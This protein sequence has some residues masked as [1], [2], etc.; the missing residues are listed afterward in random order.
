MEV[1]QDFGQKI[2]LAVRIRDILHDYPEGTSVLKELIQNADDAGATTI[3]F[4]L[5]ERHHKTER[6]AAQSLASFQ[7]P[8]LLAFNDAVFSEADFQS[9]SS[10]GQSVKREQKGKT[11]RFGVGFNASYHLS[12]VVSFISGSQLVIFD[13]HCTYLPNITPQNPG[14]RINFVA[15]SAV[16]THP[17]QFAP[18]QAFGCNARSY[19]DGTLFRFPL[20]TAKQAA[21]SRISKQVYSVEGVRSVLGDLRKEAVSALLFL[22]SL[23]RLEIY[24]WTETA[25][26]PTVLFTCRLSNASPDVLADRCFFSA[27]AAKATSENGG[28]SAT[29]STYMAIFE[30]HAST[31]AA[32]DRQTFLISQSSGGSASAALAAE[33][34]RAFNVSVVPYAAVAGLLAEPD[35]DANQPLDGQAFCFLPITSTGLPV[36]VNGFFEL[37]SNRRDIWHGKGMAGDVAAPSYANLLAKAAQRLGPSPAFYKL[38]PVQPVR[39]P[40]SVLVTAL[41]REL[42]SRQVVHTAAGGGRWLAPDHAVYIDGA[43][44]R[45]TALVDALIVVGVPVASG[46]PEVVRMLVQHIVQQPQLLCPATLRDHIRSAKQAVIAACTTDI[47]R[48]AVLLAYCL[49]DIDDRD[50]D[51]CLE[52]VGLP[53]LPLLDGT[54]KTMEKM[55]SGQHVYM[56]SSLERH[57]LGAQA[58][59]LVDTEALSSETAHRLRAVACTGCLNLQLVDSRALVDVFLPNLLPQAWQG[60]AVVTW[61][62]G[63]DGAPSVEWIAMLWQE[64]QAFDDLSIFSAWPLLPNASGELTAL[65]TLDRSVVTWEPDEAE[66]SVIPALRKLGLKHLSSSAGVSHHKLHRHVHLGNGRGILAAMEV[67]SAR[68]GPSAG[69]LWE[70][71]FQTA[72]ITLDERRALRRF[73]LQERWLRGH[74]EHFKLL[75]QLPIF[76][77]ANSASHTTE[78][79][80]AP[81]FVTLLGPSFIAPE[82]MPC[83]ALPGCFVEVMHDAERGALQLLGVQPLSRSEVLRRHVLGRLREVAAPARQAVMLYTLSHL[84]LMVAEDQAILDHLRVTPFVDTECGKLQSPGALYD[85]RI[86][87]LVALLDSHTAFPSAPFASEESLAALQRVGL[88]STVSTATLL[89][90][91]RSIA[92]LASHSQAAARARGEVLLEYLEVEAG[93]LLSHAHVPHSGVE[94]LINRVSA[95]RNASGASSSPETARF[96]AELGGLAWCPVL[97]KAPFEGLPWPTQHEL[98][99][100]PRAIRPL[101]DLW[102]CCGTMRILAA[103]CR[104]AVLAE[105][106]GWSAPINGSV[107]GTQ[108]ASLGAMHPAG[109]VTDVVLQQR[110]ARAVPQIYTCL[111]SLSR[112]DMEVVSAILSDAPCIWTGN[113]FVPAARVAFRGPLNLSPWLYC[114][115]GDLQPFKGLLIDLGVRESFTAD[116]YVGVLTDMAAGSGKALSAA[117][118]EQAISVLQALSDMHVGAEKLYILDSRGCLAPASDLVYNDAPW[119]PDQQSRFVHP[120]LSNEV[121]EKL[122]VKSLRRMMLADSAATMSLGLHSVE[123]FGQSEAL[124]TRLKHII[125]DYADGPGIL[126]ELLQNA[127]DAGAS[128]VAFMLDN[129]QYGTNSVLGQDTKVDRP[130]TTGRFGLGFN[131]VYHWTD[132]PGFVSGDYLVM[133]DPHAKWLPGTSPAQ[134]G[135]KIAFQ[136]ADLLTQFPDAFEPFLHFKCNLRES[137]PGTLFRFPLRTEELA[138]Q[139]EIKGQAYS[140][141][142]VRLLFDGMRTHI[143]RTLLFLKNVR[144]AAV[145]VRE[146]GDEAPRLLFRAS[147]ETMDGRSSQAAICRYIGE[148]GRAERE[149]LYRRLAQADAAELPAVQTTATVTIEDLQGEE[150]KLLVQSWLISNAL[151]GR[152]ARS[153]AVQMQKAGRGLVPWAGVAVPLHPSQDASPEAFSGPSAETKADHSLMGSPAA[154]PAQALMGQAFCF[155]PLPCSTGLPVHVNGYFE[156]SSNRRSIWFSDLPS[157]L[158]GQ[159]KVRSDWNLALLE[160]LAAPLYARLLEECAKRCGPTDAYFSLWPPQNLAPP[161]SNLAAQL[162]KEVAFLKVAWTDSEGGR[163]IAP[164]DALLPHEAC[165]ADSQLLSAFCREGMP[166]VTGT[167]MS[168]LSSWLTQTPG[169]RTITPS[170]AREYLR[171]K[172]ARFG[173]KQRPPQ[174]LADEAAAMLAYCLADLDLSNPEAVAQLAGLHIVQTLQGG[175]VALQPCQAG[176]QPFLLATGEQQQL[177]PSSQASLVLHCQAESELGGKLLAVASSGPLN[178]KPLTAESLAETVLPELLPTQWRSQETLVWDPEAAA[179]GHVNAEVLR[180]LW[181]LLATLPDLSALQAW[182]LV[183]V[184]KNRLC[185]LSIP[186]KVVEE[187]AWAEGVTAALS[188]LG[189]HVLDSSVLPLADMGS[190]RSLV[191]AATGS[192]VL[193]AISNAAGGDLGRVG[194]NLITGGATSAERQQLRIFLLQE[195]W[196]SGSGCVTMEQHMLLKALPVYEAAAA[197]GAETPGGAFLDLLEDRFL[198]PGGTDEALLAPSFLKPAPAG[199]A[200]VLV[201]RLGVKMLTQQA[202]ITDHV[203]PRLQEIAP[204]ARDAAMLHLLESIHNVM[205]QNPA[206]AKQLS[207]TAFV[208]TTS[209][210]AAPASLYDPR[211]EDLVALLDKNCHFPSGVFAKDDKVLDALKA[212]GLR[213]EVTLETLL[214]AARS[215]EGLTD[216]TEKDVD[217]ASLLL[218]KLNEVATQEQVEDQVSNDLTGTNGDFWDKMKMLCWCPVVTLPPHPDMPFATASGPLA[219][220]RIARQVQDAWICS[221]CL[222]LVNGNPGPALA[223]KLGWTAPL[224]APTLGAQLLELGK[225]HSQVED[226]LLLDVLEESAMQIYAG[227]QAR[228]DNQAEL[229]AVLVMLEDSACIWTG[230]GF[231]AADCALMSLDHDCAPYLHCVPDVAAPYKRL[232]EFLGVADALTVGHATRALQ[233]LAKE[234]GP[235]ALSERQLSLAVQLAKSLAQLKA[236]GASIHDQVWL[237][238]NE[239]VMAVSR[240]IFFD[241]APWLA[242]SGQRL[243]HPDIPNDVAE[244]L[245]AQSLRYHHQVNTRM[246]A[247]LPCAPASMLAPLLAAAAEDMTHALFDIAE[248]ADA[249]GCE[250]MEVTLDCRQHGTES[251]LL[252]GLA[253]FQGPALC[254]MLSGVVL[255]REELCQLQCPGTPYK[256]RGKTCRCGTGLLSCYYL[257]DLLMA[258][259]GDSLYIWDPHGHHLSA[260]GKKDSAV[261]AAKQYQHVGGQSDLVSRFHDQFAIWDFG[262]PAVHVSSRVASTLIR[263]PLRS[264]SQAQRSSVCTDPWNEERAAQLMDQFSQNCGR[265]ML[266]MQSLRCIRTNHILKDSSAATPLSQV[267]LF[268]HDRGNRVVFDDKDWRHKSLG[269][270]VRGNRFPGIR[271]TLSFSVVTTSG[272]N[273]D[274]AQQLWLVCANAGLGAARD[275][276]VDRRY[277]AL[278]LEPT[279]AIAICFDSANS[280]KVLPAGGVYAPLP[281]HLGRPAKAAT[282]FEG[283]L[284]FLVYAAFAVSR[285]GGRHIAGADSGHQPSTSPQGPQQT[286]E[287]LA[288]FNT[289]LMATGVVS[290]WLEAFTALQGRYRIPGSAAFR[291]CSGIYEMV[292]S[293]T[294]GEEDEQQTQD[295]KRASKTINYIASQVCRDIAEKPLWQ[296][297]D[298]RMITL[299][300]GCFIQPNEDVSEL[301]A[302]AL[303]FIQSKMPLFNIPWRI[304]TAL[305]LSGVRDCNTVTPKAVRPL[306]KR[307]MKTGDGMSALSAMEAAEL[308]QFCFQ[309]IYSLTRD[310]EPEEPLPEHGQH[311]LTSAGGADAGGALRLPGVPQNLLDDILGNAANNPHVQ[312]TMSYFRDALGMDVGAAARAPAPAHQQEVPVQPA[313]AEAAPPVAPEV[314]AVRQKR[315]QLAELL[316]ECVGLPAPNARGKIVALGAHRLFMLPRQ[317]PVRPTDVLPN[318]RGL[319]DTLL[320]PVVMEYLGEC[321]ARP[322]V[323]GLLNLQAFTLREADQALQHLLPP[324]WARGSSVSVAWQGGMQGGPKPEKLLQLWQ[325]LLALRDAHPSAD[326]ASLNRWPLIPSQGARGSMVRVAHRA[327]VF[328]PPNQMQEDSTP[329]GAAQRAE[330]GPGSTAAEASAPTVQEVSAASLA[331]QPEGPASQLNGD[332]HDQETQPLLNAEQQAGDTATSNGIHQVGRSQQA[333]TSSSAEGSTAAIATVDNGVSAEMQQAAGPWEWLLPVLERLSLPVLDSRFS[334]LAPVCALDGQLSEQDTILRKLQLC[335]EGGLFQVDQLGEMDCQHLFSYFAER[336]PSSADAVHLDFLRSLPIFPSLLPGRHVALNTGPHPAATCPRSQLTAA[337]G[338]ISALPQHVQAMLLDYRPECEH[339]YQVLEVPTMLEPL[340]MANIILPHFGELAPSMQEHVMARILEQWQSWR[341]NVALFDALAVTPFVTTA[342]GEGRHARDLYNPTN[343]LLAKIFRDRPVFPIAQFSTSPWIQV[344]CQIGLRSEI[345]HVTF[346]A[347]ARELESWG[348]QMLGMNEEQAAES[349]VVARELVQELRSNTALL[350]NE[351]F[352]ALRDVAF[353]PATKG[354]PG[355]NEA[356]PV[357]VR[358]SEAVLHKDWPLAW[359]A[360]PILEEASIPP[361]SAWTGLG[362]RSPPLFS[363]VLAHLRALSHDCGQAALSTW[364]ARG[365][366]AEQAFGAVLDYISA[367]G[368]TPNQAKELSH[369]ALI[370]VANGTRL[371]APS[372]LYVRLRDDLSPFAFELPAALVGRSTIIQELGMKSEPTAADLINFLQGLRRTLGSAPLNINEVRAVL[373]LLRYICQHKDPELLRLLS[374][375]RAADAVLV[376]AADSRLVPASA[377]VH[378][379]TC[380]P[381]LLSRAAECVVC[382]HPQLPIDICKLLGIAALED[383]A[384]ETLDE[385]EP[386]QYQ[387]TIQ[388]QSLRSV[389]QLLKSP[390]MAQAIHQVVSPYAKAV[391][392]LALTAKEVGVTLSKAADALHFVKACHTT[393]NFRA[394]RAVI[395]PKTPSV[396][397]YDFTSAQGDAILVA[398]PPAGIQLPTL[399]SRALSRTL[400]SPLAL[401]VEPLLSCAAADLSVVRRALLPATPT[402]GG[403]LELARL[404]T[405]G[406]LGSALLP[407]DLALVQL[408]PLRPFAAGEMCA[409]MAGMSPTVAAARAAQQRAS[410]GPAGGGQVLCYGRVACDARPD[411]GAAVFRVQVEVSPGQIADL[412]SSEVYSFRNSSGGPGPAEHNGT[413]PSEAPPPNAGEATSNGAAAAPEPASGA[414]AQPAVAP[415]EVV[416]AIRD[417]LSAADLPL[418]LEQERLLEQ[419]LSLQQQL[420]ATQAALNHQQAV[421]ESAR[422]EGEAAR[423]AWRCRICL[424]ADVDAVMTTCGHALCW[425]CGSACRQRCPFCRTHSPVIRLYK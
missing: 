159:G 115:P 266:F 301:G 299:S 356:R 265:M 52:L 415:G 112:H 293:G 318:E 338:D 49:Q 424:S 201:E 303:H 214:D 83:S 255:S 319:W 425:N 272:D 258:V 140:P 416:S 9:I 186:S 68:T 407:S 51:S 346:L 289:D 198:A 362:L 423:E 33:A 151:G 188:R 209:A 29:C 382:A 359:A 241:D 340:L 56:S 104:S 320:H 325:L 339:L 235:L 393:V 61:N 18:Y 162:Y 394:T 264:I 285:S 1:W 405:A 189:V 139:S 57:L 306:L 224:A 22:K 397:V 309:D 135:L 321:L 401:P 223:S 336:V 199:E 119:V 406:E 259:S 69:S 155:L 292:P 44:Q 117:Q 358:C 369:L 342:S 192:G 176:V 371:V 103:E 331:A 137:F 312:A 389:Q 110:L 50:P 168:L 316:L 54:I 145:Y 81:C 43:V 400:H 73:L 238:D 94:G 59:L 20:R 118:Q 53:L 90:S 150:R 28:N 392:A 156:L 205:A 398:D 368:V 305:E 381:H 10:I 206:L 370:P 417:M 108:L 16:D 80:P 239:H 216:V 126:M 185:Q 277:A 111:S 412:L 324:L 77:T 348:L 213:S 62:A 219:P 99:A 385:R 349:I 274:V 275:L 64:L 298:G 279:T 333:T 326:V 208:T 311:P 32:A 408:K 236:E 414:S 248:L 422:T 146:A 5:D 142:S 82:G 383:I 128:E 152:R 391:P 147:M 386:L 106:L 113:G 25:E 60:Q 287:V 251:L 308:L 123:A 345:N 240:H 78:T 217:R 283:K 284:P 96:W 171:A 143:E 7:G 191:N 420:K 290:A 250:T 263:L 120:K 271:K 97:A 89:D 402:T 220:P 329:S 181:S 379:L 72:G 39:E 380:P 4:C 354:L 183:P 233:G 268:S 376:P 130:A 85:P 360:A 136:R 8:A 15:S 23:Q 134:P 230:S 93:R 21:N 418:G 165:T 166:L 38:W 226:E 179:S 294:R 317:C 200:R 109:Q 74:P 313:A 30:S 26:E 328:C 363:T 17:D 243:V 260:S 323:A 281:L 12:D 364:P 267:S 212:L 207:V 157:D 87:E 387:A 3:R 229:D 27:V 42:S 351:L 131:A 211:N 261:S 55:T 31:A 395:T 365:P 315:R 40:W 330:E 245:G 372:S 98:V 421:A 37:S 41:Y 132:V 169:T 215:L 280:P 375:M 133:F 390:E 48:A 170:W 273:G 34:S 114:I 388:G 228:M 399:L 190:A 187:G 357:L 225:L 100:P 177:L 344:L 257:T 218:E 341:D 361:A 47:R 164:K 411:A 6:L 95:F 231:V 384:C 46:P 203:L 202:L 355:N 269:Q 66:P 242:G 92:E 13:P 36:H 174:E 144:S 252:P 196:F 410:K 167:P 153:L 148:G 14:K 204:K 314:E 105:G 419:S 352:R 2:D 160:D 194:R 149:A 127:D 122:G 182:P 234:Q 256:I 173:L 210:L 413:R 249:V 125:D 353:V 307:M 175:L 282:L 129:H 295:V 378:T 101:Q 116:Q 180:K 297:R 24:E 377:C 58:A 296:L 227:I 270:L 86:P 107:V 75:R 396:Q 172:G 335:S 347:C 254:I 373:R 45:D 278:Q 65:T 195:R 404:G 19:F 138:K 334:M 79:E 35:A 366:R 193:A 102:F 288:A 161:W 141:S 350:S 367:Q 304:K 91:A 403:G 184:H 63:A 121:S 221:A 327:L 300:H 332:L 247:D 84:P 310:L 291:P 158:A 237:P 67:L 343:T 322:D 124:T 286:Q 246:T 262:G 88:R 70:H 197:P 232:F 178:L 222:R 276:A 71:L 244:A 302:A 11:G 337:V 76:E 374:R 163:W 154:N 409:Y 253:E